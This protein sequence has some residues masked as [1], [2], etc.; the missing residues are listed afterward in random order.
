MAGYIRGKYYNKGDSFKFAVKFDGSSTSTSSNGAAKE[1]AAGTTAWYISH[2]V[3]AVCPI[4]VCTTNNTWT[5]GWY[6]LQVIPWATYPV[7]LDANGGSGVAAS[8]TKTWGTNL[9]LPEPTT[10]K[11][12][13]TSDGYKVTYSYGNGNANTSVTVKDTTSYTFGYWTDASSGATI[14]QPFS[15]VV[16]DGL[17]NNN[18]GSSAVSYKQEAAPASRS[19]KAYWV[20]S[21]KRGSVTLPTPTWANTSTS[22]LI[23]YNASDNGGTAS[24]S[25]ENYSLSITHT[26][27][28]WYNGS[29][30]VGKG[31]ASYTPTANV[32]LTGNWTNTTTGTGT[33]VLP[34]ATK[35]NGTASRT[36]TI[37]ANGGSTTVSSRKSTATV[38]YT[39]NGWWTKATNGDKVGNSGATIT[40]ATAPIT[41]YAQFTS[42]TGSYSS[43]KLPTASECTRTNYDLK[44]FATSS[45]ATTA[46]YAPGASYT[47]SANVTL[48]AVWE[49][50]TGKIY[51]KKN[52]AWV[53]AKAVYTKVN[54]AWV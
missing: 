44:G 7:Y 12:S 20:D 19:F 2:S 45:T 14:P 27:N 28:G 29:T 3:G 23:T 34:T 25:S 47:P 1:L 9:T 50:T 40:P 43:V 48:Y 30:N 53:E 21:F 33:I 31:G 36:V 11:P 41:Y 38:T 13:V 51:V 5:D 54:G 49:E 46:S 16:D 8:V 26:F 37:N 17:I 52:G 15:D 18:A 22:G 35:A 39:S 24:K 32:T 6:G 4:A 42:A 10:A